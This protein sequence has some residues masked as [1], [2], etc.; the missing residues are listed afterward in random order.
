[1]AK[2]T[3]PPEA[4]EPPEKVYVPDEGMMFSTCRIER[5]TDAYIVIEHPADWTPEQIAAAVGKRRGD[6]A[7]RTRWRDATTSTTVAEVV[8]GE[9]A[10]DDEDHPQEPFALTAEDLTTEAPI[11]VVEASAE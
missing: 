9:Y 10:P 4:P 7:E 2:L 1:M 6:L 8:R 11:V 3:E 5:K